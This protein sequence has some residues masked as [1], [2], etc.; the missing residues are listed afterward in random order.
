[1]SHSRRKEREEPGFAATRTEAT[2]PKTN[3]VKASEPFRFS[4]RNDVSIEPSSAVIRPK[5]ELMSSLVNRLFPLKLATRWL[6]VT[7][8]LGHWPAVF[9]VLAPLGQDMRGFRLGIG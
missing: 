5:D 8:Q 1:M 7:P 4:S 3:L 9:D 6:D 2:R